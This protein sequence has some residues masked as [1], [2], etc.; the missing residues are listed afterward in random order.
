[1][2]GGVG[3]GI[4]GGVGGGSGV[5]IGSRLGGLHDRSIG[6]RLQTKRPT[7]STLKSAETAYKC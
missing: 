4:G 3:G 7:S 5:A 1:M 6:P 2:G